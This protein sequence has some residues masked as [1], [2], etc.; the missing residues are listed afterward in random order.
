MKQIRIVLIIS[1]VLLSK[2]LFATSQFLEHFIVNGETTVML[3]S[4]PLEQYFRQKGE[5]TIGGV[6]MV[7][8][9]TASLRGYVATWKLENDSLFLTHIS[10]D[11][12][13]NV[14]VKDEFGSDRVF[15]EWVNDTIAIPQGERIH[16]RFFEAEKHFVF[17]NGK[18]K[19]TI[20]V[21]HLVRDDSLLFPNHIFLQDTIRNLVLNSI[22]EVQRESIDV[23]EWVRLTVAFNAFGVI[24]DIRLGNPN[25]TING[26]IV[27]GNAREILREF[28]RLMRMVHTNDIHWITVSFSGSD[29]KNSGNQN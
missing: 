20:V 2:N 17:E 3:Y 23:E 1:F 5:R 26:K 11:V 28:P 9:T 15:A 13:R 16:F 10:P 25:E 19:D 21:N 4:F 27:L 12:D 8:T 6:E 7:G 18:L 24:S 14:G 29:L 22:N